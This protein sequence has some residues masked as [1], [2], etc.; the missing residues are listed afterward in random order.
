MKKLPRHVVE[1]N[2]RVQRKYQKALK[3]AR[4]TIYSTTNKADRREI[5]IEVAY[6]VDQVERYGFKF[7]PDVYVAPLV[8]KLTAISK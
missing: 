6:L 3:N 1:I 4:K 2:R 5:E 8:E 7:F